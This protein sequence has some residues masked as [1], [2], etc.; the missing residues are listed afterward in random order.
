MKFILIISV[1]SQLYGNCMPPL[2]HDNHF[3]SHY[4][5]ATKGYAIAESMMADLGQDYVN[6]E[7]IVIGFKCRPKVDI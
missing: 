3:N 2:V 5:C 7:L 1:C 4:G 6:N